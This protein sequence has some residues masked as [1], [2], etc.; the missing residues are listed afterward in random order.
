[1]QTT[2][3]FIAIELNSKYFSDIFVKLYHYLKENSIEKYF[4]FQNPLSVHITLYYLE[5]DISEWQRMEIKKF[6]KNFDV[7]EDIFLSGFK[8]FYRNEKRFLLYLKPKSNIHFENFRNIFHKKFQKNEIEDNNF[9]FVSHITFFKILPEWQEIFENHRKNI[10]KNI[11]EEIGKL[12]WK[13]VNSGKM[14]LYAVN[15][16]FKEEIQVKL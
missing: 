2:S 5:K 14:Y 15:S 3:H 12:Q 1:M 10:E 4:I 6:L 8:Y 16:T 7:N 9:P 13:N 11:S